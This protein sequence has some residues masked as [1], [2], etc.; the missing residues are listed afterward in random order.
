MTHKFTDLAD[1]G[2]EGGGLVFMKKY[3]V[4]AL[5][6]DIEDNFAQPTGKYTH[7]THDSKA[8]AELAMLALEREFWT[9][10]PI[11]NVIFFFDEPL[12]MLAAELFVQKELKITFDEVE[13]L[14]LD[15]SDETLSA[16]LLKT[17]S[18]ICWLQEVGDGVDQYIVKAKIWNYD[19]EFFQLGDQ[20]THS[21]HFSKSSAER[22]RADLEREFWVGTSL[23]KVAIFAED[24]SKSEEMRVFL[25][26]E[27][28]ITLRDDE[29]LPLSI[30]D[31]ALFRF[32]KE[33]GVRSSWISKVDGGKKFF[34]LRLLKSNAYMRKIVRK[35]EEEDGFDRIVYAKSK[36]E[37]RSLSRGNLI[38]HFCFKA[39]YWCGDYESEITLTGELDE[40]SQN[41]VKLEEL[42]NKYKSIRYKKTAKKLVVGFG[43]LDAIFEINEILNS[44]IFSIEELSMQQIEDIEEKDQEAAENMFKTHSID[45]IFD[46]KKVWLYR[47]ITK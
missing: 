28:D 38:H 35:W 15:I 31:E 32:L 22:S 42:V 8:S 29:S 13:C 6:W 18:N 44:P 23:S 12:R 17:K 4:K 2:V 40:L 39:D 47:L 43:N 46:Q 30:S 10:I 26:R 27:F 37:L 3:R 5:R 7:S 14:P 45:N 34:V 41:S 1:I 25:K 11:A 33:A 24:Q 21:T 36:S 19:G 20:F 9:K 16:F